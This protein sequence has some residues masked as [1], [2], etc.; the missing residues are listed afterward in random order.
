[1]SYQKHFPGLGGEDGGGGGG[2]DG[3]GGGGGGGEGEGPLFFVGGPASLCSIWW[4][5]F[6]AG[7]P[8]PSL[9][10]PKYDP[11]PR[12]NTLSPLTWRVRLQVY[13][14]GDN[15]VRVVEHTV[16]RRRCDNRRQLFAG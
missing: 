1:M 14:V 10:C 9:P 3:G 12:T 5:P 8:G 2:V 13:V 11:D 7:T 4:G 15:V 6:L 16:A